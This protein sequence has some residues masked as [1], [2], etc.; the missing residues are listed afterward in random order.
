MPNAIAVDL[1]RHFNN[2]EDAD[3]GIVE[4]DTL[5]YR[6]HAS[7]N[8]QPSKQVG[9]IA[10]KP[11]APVQFT[12]SF[13]DDLANAINDLAIS[14]HRKLHPPADGK[15]SPSPQLPLTAEEVQSLENSDNDEGEDEE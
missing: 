11:N 3:L 2:Y 13:T 5:Q 7:V 14:E 12:R 9:F 6:V 10:A 15:S 4:Q 8:G 1:I